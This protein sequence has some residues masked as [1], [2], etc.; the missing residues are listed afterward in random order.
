MRDRIL[1]AYT[2][3]TRGRRHLKQLDLLR[4]L[5]KKKSETFACFKSRAGTVI[6]EVN[7]IDCLPPDHML[8][9]IIKRAISSDDHYEITL[10][11]IIQNTPDNITP[12]LLLDITMIAAA[13]VKRKHSPHKYVSA[14]MNL[15]IMHLPQPPTILILPN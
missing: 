4:D 8:L 2:K 15:T 10:Q 5:R 7:S 3:S 14:N 11:L 9:E 6:E 12:Q 1:V 13:E